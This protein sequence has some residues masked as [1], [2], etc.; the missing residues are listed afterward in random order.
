MVNKLHTSVIG[1]GNGGEN[2]LIKMVQLAKSQLLEKA[3]TVCRHPILP[4]LKTIDGSKIQ[5]RQHH[6]LYRIPM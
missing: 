1:H 5:V 4:P 2:I 6:T 3:T